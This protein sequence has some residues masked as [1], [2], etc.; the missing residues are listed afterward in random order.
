[1]ITATHYQ[2]GDLGPD[3]QE[4]VR[5][6]GRQAA[7]GGRPQQR[8]RR[9]RLDQPSRCLPGGDAGARPGQPEMDHR[10][11][12]QDHRRVGPPVSNDPGEVEGAEP[13]HEGQGDARERPGIDPARIEVRRIDGVEQGRERVVDMAADLH[14]A[15]QEQQADAAEEAGEHRVGQE[16]HQQG[17]PQGAEQREDHAGGEGRDAAGDEHELAD[18][19][20]IGDARGLELP[21]D[22]RG[23]RRLHDRG[24]ADEGQRDPRGA[25]QRDEDEAA[26]HVGR[27]QRRQAGR[28]ALH[29]RP[30]EDELG[31]ADEVEEQHHHGDGRRRSDAGPAQ[32]RRAA[33]GRGCG[34]GGRQVGC[35]HRHGT[36]VSK[37]R[38]ARRSQIPGQ[39]P[40]D[41]VHGSSPNRRT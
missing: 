24:R 10:E 17:G 38:W 6:E 3:R 1:M 34:P 31:V 14:A 33:A 32:D 23:D 39:I 4:Q 28:A 22:R 2:G 12:R 19:L 13:D 30:R 21:G 37:S 26:Q 16:L 29:Q 11:A 20:R 40:C 41:H 18:R 8:A 5:I 27:E 25:A 35:R 15:A 7:D 9:Q 36:R